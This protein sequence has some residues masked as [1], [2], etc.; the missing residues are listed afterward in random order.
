MS[1]D[2]GWMRHALA[3]AETAIYRTAPNPRVGCVIVR[4]GRVVGEGATQPV[5]GPHAEICAM[6]DAQARGESLQGTTFYVTLEPCSHHGRTPPCADALVAAMPARVVVAMG[7]PNPRVNG[8]GIARLRAAGIA[9]TE[10]VCLDEALSLNVGFA[11]RMSRGTP[12]LWAKMAASLDGR[13]A[14]H[15]GQSQWITGEAAR[16]D[17]HHWRARSC[18]VLTGMGTVLADDPRLDV[19]HVETPRQP[20]K[21]VIDADLRMPVG[22]KLLEGAQTWIFTAADDAARTRALEDR[23]ARVIVMPGVAG[24]VD[25]PGVL[26]C[27]GQHEINEVHA[28]AGA[29]LTGALWQAGCVDELLVYLAP[30]LLG[31]AVGM[32]RLPALERLADARRFVFGDVRMIGGDARLRAHDGER[33]AALRRACEPSAPERA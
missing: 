27:L 31:D 5:G 1:D 30:M 29:G 19:R 22:A 10:G 26:R 4:D 14:L 6:R 3:L 18:A 32:A 21:I 11:A 20:R 13:S 24:R 8:Q 25:L 33:L 9:V 28:E 2:I 12:W 17:G 23:G 16:A 7:D 15:N